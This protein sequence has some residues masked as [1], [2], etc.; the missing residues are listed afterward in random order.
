MIF[1]KN[2]VVVVALLL[3]VSLQ[4]QAHA[5]IAPALGVS[6]TP[7]RTDVQRPSNAKPCGNANIAQTFDSSRTVSL[8][9]DGTFSATIQNFNGGV[10]GSRQITSAKVDVTGKGNKFVAAQ[11]IKNG[12]RSPTA[13]GTEE[14][15]I[16]I[17]SQCTGGKSKNKCL[18]SLTTAGGFG[19]CVVVQSAAKKRGEDIGAAG[20]RAARTMRLAEGDSV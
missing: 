13:V 1:G 8:K 9:A 5:A 16:K 7:K 15:T 6:G 4:V 12:Q 2:P 20:T 10:D 11:V 14:L 17:P 3:S 18:V 19:N